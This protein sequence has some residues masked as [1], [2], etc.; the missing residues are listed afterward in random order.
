[1]ENSN[2]RLSVFLILYGSFSIITDLWRVLELL[3]Y[4][5]VYPNIVDTI[6]CIL[7]A[8]SL[9]FNVVFAEKEI[10]K[11]CFDDKSNI[12]GDENV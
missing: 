3:I 8:I 1:M 4:N 12:K 2:F 5:K 11:N 9:T 10:K 6:I 7:F